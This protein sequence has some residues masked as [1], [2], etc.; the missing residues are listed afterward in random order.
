MATPLTQTEEQEEQF[1]R[2]EDTVSVVS[3]EDDPADGYCQLCVDKDRPENTTSMVTYMC[4]HQV[5][6]HC[7]FST[8][9]NDTCNQC[10]DRIWRLRGHVE[11]TGAD[12]KEREKA[13]EL[14]DTDEEFQT[15]LLKLKQS[16]YTYSSAARA[17]NKEFIV[18]NREFRHTIR[19]HVEAIRL[20]RKQALTKVKALD[21]TKRLR[22]ARSLSARRYTSILRNYKLTSYGLYGLHTKRAHGKRLD[23]LRFTKW[24]YP[25]N[26]FGPWRRRT[27]FVR[28]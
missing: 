3:N 19:P 26:A 18:I 22:S 15:A 25:R 17:Y 20:Y 27:F 16:V 5:H 21:A 11:E 8:R 9:W 4:G 14:L 12:K 10:E 24:G 28:P 23:F 2:A 13:Q 1:H 6:S 7:F